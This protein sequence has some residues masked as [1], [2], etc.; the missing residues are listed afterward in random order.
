MPVSNNGYSSIEH[1]IINNYI[2]L[3]EF[4]SLVSYVPQLRRLSFHLLEDP[5]MKRTKMC[6]FVLNHL[7]YISFKSNS[8]KFDQLGQLIIDL[9]P[10]VQVLHLTLTYNIDPS[11]INAN[12]WK[13]LIASHIPN[14]RIWDIEFD[15]SAINYDNRLEIET[16]INQFTSPFWIER[17]WFFAHHIYQSK[18]GNRL[19]FYS[20][21]PYR[22]L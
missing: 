2:Y 22:Y 8:I 6:P 14:L 4:D 21:N 11:C 20:T 12:K 16:Q 5:W 1:L 19:I 7:T 17:Q 13:Q 3:H 10:N 15:F 18:W 9:F